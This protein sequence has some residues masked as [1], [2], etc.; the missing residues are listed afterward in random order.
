MA[1]LRRNVVGEFKIEDF[2][3][4]V[5][6]SVSRTSETESRSVSKV[7]GEGRVSMSA[8]VPANGS[9]RESVALEAD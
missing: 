3:R 1:R 4:V 6:S 9:I 2:A 8:V 7:E 5:V